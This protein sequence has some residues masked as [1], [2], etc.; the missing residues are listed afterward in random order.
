[1]FVHLGQTKESFPVTAVRKTYAHIDIAKFI[2]AFFVVAIHVR[3]FDNWENPTVDALFYSAAAV[4]V[5]YFFIASGFLCFARDEENPWKTG[6]QRARKQAKAVLE[7]YL[8]WTLIYLPI[9]AFGSMQDGLSV[10]EAVIR[11][12]QGTIFVGENIWAW[13]LWYLLALAVALA[14]VSLFARFAA[15]P[16][17]LAVFATAMLAAGAGLNMLNHAETLP[18]AIAPLVDGYFDLFYTTRN[19]LFEGLFYVVCGVILGLNQHVVGQLKAPVIAVIA[20]ISYLGCVTITP[21]AQAPFC[22]VLA[23]CIFALTART[24]TERSH[25]WMRSANTIIYLVHMI[26]FVVV[27]YGVCGHTGSYI[28]GTDYNHMAVYLL[29]C[30]LSIA[31]AALGIKLSAKCGLLKRI[32]HC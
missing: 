6:G 28:Y 31:T 13:P 9:I 16:R 7:L 5:P 19:G 3:P 29:V 15:T 24:K 22:A 10:S 26:F 20:A 32:F 4:A 1:M 14:V 30:A 25:R 18:V 27:V 23:I 8:I 11:F 2:L 21:S 17:G 12:V